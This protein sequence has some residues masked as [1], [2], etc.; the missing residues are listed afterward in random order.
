MRPGIR[1]GIDVGSVRV[2]LARS[3]RDGILATPL[4][5]VQ[6]TLNSPKHFERIVSIVREFEVV[7]VI[8]GLPRSLSGREGSAADTV[9]TYAIEVAQRVAPIPVRLVDERL[10]TVTAHNRLREAGMKGQK[11]RPIVDQVAAIVI[12]QS[13]LDTERSTGRPPGSLVG[14]KPGPDGPSPGTTDQRRRRDQV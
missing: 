1:L 10:S 11:R 13:A 5:T 8:I 4:E 9:R 3:D 2:G 7:E 6:V 12:L 14:P